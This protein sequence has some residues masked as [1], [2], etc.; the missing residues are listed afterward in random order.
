MKIESNGG[1]YRMI[2]RSAGGTVTVATGTVEVPASSQTIHFR[3]VPGNDWQ[4]Q[5][6]ADV[7]GDHV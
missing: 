4:P 2:S 5:R 6:G 7:H 3:R 1:R